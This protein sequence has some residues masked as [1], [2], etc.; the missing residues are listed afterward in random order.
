MTKRYYKIK[1]LLKKIGSLGSFN[2]EVMSSL[3]NYLRDSS[4]SIDH[5][6]L[7][8]RL[9]NII[10]YSDFTKEEQD[11]ATAIRSS[12]EY[13]EWASK[14][15]PGELNAFDIENKKFWNIMG[16]TP[17]VTY[18]DYNPSGHIQ[19]G[20]E[21]K[22]GTEGLSPRR[23]RLNGIK[24]KQDLYFSFELSESAK[25]DPQEALGAIKNYLKWILDVVKYCSQVNNHLK[26]QGSQTHIRSLKFNSGVNVHYLAGSLFDEKDSL[27]IYFVNATPEFLR[28]FYENVLSLKSKYSGF[29]TNEKRQRLARGFD[30]SG[31]PGLGNMSFGQ[32]LGYRM[33]FHVTNN[34]SYIQS[35]LDNDQ[36]QR[37]FENFLGQTMKGSQAELIIAMDKYIRQTDRNEIERILRES[38]IL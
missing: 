1:S 10:R 20:F 12:D 17:G 18:I 22:I 9:Y 14:V 26:Q 7:A 8:S 25:D 23:R 19:V 31:V 37:E 35:L 29:T 27:K 32:I 5:R 6:S 13:K 4:R 28:S 34:I 30:L 16:S 38:K 2:D 33:A 21:Y 24:L 15:D 36:G 11:L 3:W